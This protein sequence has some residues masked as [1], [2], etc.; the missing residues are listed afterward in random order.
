MGSGFVIEVTNM[1][2]DKNQGWSELRNGV[3]AGEEELL[4]VE[5][6]RQL[7]GGN[8]STSEST[9]TDTTPERG[10]GR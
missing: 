3:L 10:S 4:S 1:S 5:E 2:L 9:S 7:F 8:G 6:L